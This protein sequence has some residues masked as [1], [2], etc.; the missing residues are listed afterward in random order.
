MTAHRSPARDYAT[1]RDLPSPRFRPSPFGT[2]SGPGWSDLRRPLAFT[3]L[4]TGASFGGA[5]Y[6]D[7][8]TGQEP[9]PD[10]R[11]RVLTTLIA[12]NLAVFATHQVLPYV[13]VPGPL[14]RLV[15][16]Y[17]TVHPVRAHTTPASVL[18]SG[19]SHSEVWHLGLNMVGLYTI[20]SALFDLL[21][22]NQFLAFYGSSIC[23]SSMAQL[24]A[25]VYAA[26]RRGT[27]PRGSLGASGGIYALL[28]V[29]AWYA[30]TSS[31]YLIFLPF[32]PIQLGYAFTGMIALDTLG[33]VRGWH[34]F[35]HAAHLAGG[36]G[37]LLYGVGQVPEAWMAKRKQNMRRYLSRWGR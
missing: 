35:G 12:V 16:R 4:F 1:Y 37:G 11:T 28:G 6:L 13:R 5:W 20:G 22:R 18:T 31:V 27:S 26:R 30:P 14:T 2:S 9:D 25:G 24:A 33:L 29:V 21:G 17:G 34:T 8:E 32:V 23:W 36:L 7:T 3:V 10:A 19:F 15:G